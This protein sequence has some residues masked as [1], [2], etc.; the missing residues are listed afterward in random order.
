MYI[1]TKEIIDDN[2]NK[3]VKENYI[4]SIKDN[5]ISFTNDIKSALTF[6]SY[7]KANYF[8]ENTIRFIILGRFNII[9]IKNEV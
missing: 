9:K 4:Q 5:N 6:D 8:I 7:D 3:V 2:T 1:I